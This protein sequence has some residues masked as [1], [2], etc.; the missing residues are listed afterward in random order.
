MEIINYTEL[1]LEELMHLER[2][3]ILIRLTCLLERQSNCFQEQQIMELLSSLK[4]IKVR[5]LSSF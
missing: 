3:M 5:N 2:T 1:T 4:L